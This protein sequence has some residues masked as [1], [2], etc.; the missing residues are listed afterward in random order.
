MIIQK[1]GIIMIGNIL[2]AHG[3]RKGNQNEA[4]E[5]FIGTLLKDEQYY[6]E[7][8]FLESETQNLEII[9]E[10]MIKQGITK[11]R[12]VPL[13]I[14]SAMH[15]ISDIPQIL[16]EMKARYPQIDSKMSA[17]LGTHPYMKTLVENRI[18]DEKVSEGTT[19][20][21]IVIAHGNGSG[22]FTKAHDELKAFVK[23]LDSHHPVY[24]RALYGTLAFKNDLDKISEQYDELVIVPLF[25]FDGRLVN[26]VKRLLGEMTLHSQLHITPS[27]N[28]DPILR[29]IIRERLEALDI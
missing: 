7:L 1:G 27:I 15:Y 20:A 16:K 18:A 10:K 13:L 6:Y 5:E 25:L 9:M 21:T 28:F 24:A 3:M 12:I 19:K 8:A 17:P 14:F 29:L 26:K 22:R 2:V 4:L 11:F 23:T